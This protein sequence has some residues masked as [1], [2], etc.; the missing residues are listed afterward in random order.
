MLS[1]SVET[2]ELINQVFPLIYTAVHKQCWNSEFVMCSV[3]YG[4]LV[5]YP[6]NSLIA[7]ICSVEH[8][9]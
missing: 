9:N 1:Y 5:Y 7:E 4:A 6:L 2:L 3:L 8:K